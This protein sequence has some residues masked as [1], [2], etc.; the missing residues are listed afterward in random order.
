[1]SC[2]SFESEMD[3]PDGGTPGYY[4]CRLRDLPFPTRQAPLALLADSHI[5]GL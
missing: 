1:M 3:G 2:R 4:I 5:V